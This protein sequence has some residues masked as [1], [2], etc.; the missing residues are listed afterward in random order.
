MIHVTG[1]SFV[2]APLA[3]SN[4]C[5]VYTVSGHMLYENSNPFQLIE[6]GGVLDVTGARYEQIDD[7]SVHV[8]GAVFERRPYT[9]KLEGAGGGNFQTIML[10]GIRDKKVLA[11]IDRFVDQM[12][13]ALTAKIVATLGLT[14]DDFDISLR[15]YGWNAVSGRPVAGSATTPD[16]IGL[17]FVGTA[18]SQEMATRIA[19]TCNPWFFHM[20]L[21]RGSELPS[22]GFPFSPAEIEK[23]EVHQFLLNHV[24]SVGDP[25][26]L[27]R[28]E[29][30]D[31]G[32]A[33]AAEA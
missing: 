9:M 26:E 31:L 21:D 32:N 18:R 3:A 25:M 8:E 24:V 30:I 2:V 20:P 15:A 10:V 23:G 16:E 1:D 17:L 27:V 5:S 33:D 13:T 11:E 6:P 12:Q 28:V 7:R 19:K 14:P 22:Y 4:R 29:Y